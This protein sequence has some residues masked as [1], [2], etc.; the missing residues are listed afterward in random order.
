MSVISTISTDESKLT[1]SPKLHT[2]VESGT[3]QTKEHQRKDKQ[4]SGSPVLPKRQARMAFNAITNRRMDGVLPSIPAYQQKANEEETVQTD[5][6]K[7]L[8]TNIQH[9]ASPQQ[10]NSPKL[11]PPN[12]RKTSILKD[13]MASKSVDKHVN[14]NEITNIKHHYDPLEKVRADKKK[15]EEAMMNTKIEDSMIHFECKCTIL[16]QRTY[17]ILCNAE[18]FKYS[19]YLN[20]YIHYFRC[21][22]QR[23]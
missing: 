21:I 12:K 8:P 14:I 18:Y 1:Q 16:D 9:L 7:V 3:S 19:Y 23:S 4:Q 15:L 5:A 10:T 2:P 20:Y 13:G 22:H 6:T 17:N 11:P